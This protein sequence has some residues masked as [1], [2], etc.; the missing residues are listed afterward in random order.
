MGRIEREGSLKRV[1]KMDVSS[2]VINGE[3][4]LDANERYDDSGCSPSPSRG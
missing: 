4:S 1:M 3:V 2:L